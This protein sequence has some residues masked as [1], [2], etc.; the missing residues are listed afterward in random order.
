MYPDEL[1]YSNDHEWVRR[2]GDR[3]RVGITQF[4]QDELGDVVFV[5]LPEVGSSFEANDEIGT[6]ESVKAVAEVYSPVG[7]EVVAVNEA[8]IDR[9]ELVNEDP[10]G[11]GWLVELRSEDE[12]AL[13]VLMDAAAY[14]ELLDSGG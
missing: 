12:A 5:E 4:A 3:C 2:D 9:P 6:I 14:R 13:G 8:L 11:K 1:L 10:Y 7:G